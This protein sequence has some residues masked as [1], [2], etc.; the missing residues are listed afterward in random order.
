M[1]ATNIRG[2]DLTGA[3]DSRSQVYTERTFY[4]MHVIDCCE[5]TANTHSRIF[6]QVE[7]KDS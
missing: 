6:L 5:K 3:R 4:V 7:C 2:D 1:W